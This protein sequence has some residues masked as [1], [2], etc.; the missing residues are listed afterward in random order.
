MDDINSTISQ[1]SINSN[2]DEDITSSVVVP[3]NISRTIALDETINASVAA[4]TVEA[5]VGEMT[6]TI[7]RTQPEVDTEYLRW[8]FMWQR[9]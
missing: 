3:A 2:I 7:T 8:C 9:R 4:Q 5:G 1:Q 6:I